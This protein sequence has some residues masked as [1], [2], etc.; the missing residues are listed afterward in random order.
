MTKEEE[1]PRMNALSY[2]Y[3]SGDDVQ[4]H[5]LLE[6]EIEMERKFLKRRDAVCNILECAVSM[7]KRVFIISD[8][9]MTHDMLAKLLEDFGITGYENLYVSSEYRTAKSEGLFEVVKTELN[10]E[11]LKWVH[12]GDNVYTDIYPAQKLGIETFRIYGTV[13]LLESSMYSGILENVHSLEENIVSASFAAEA[14]QDPFRI[15]GKNG[16][17]TIDTPDELGRLLIAPV[18]L[19]YITWLIGT[20]KQ[21]G[22][23][24]MVFPSRDG[25]LLKRIYDEIKAQRRD[26]QL[27]DSIYLYTSR[28]AARIAAASCKEDVYSIIEFD[29]PDNWKER[30]Q[31]RF[32]IEVDVQEDRKEVSKDLMEQLL[33]SCAKERERYQT[34]LKDTGIWNRNCGLVDFV[35]LGTVQEALEK[36]IGRSMRGYYFVRRSP[37][38]E[39]RKKMT[40][41]SL[42]PMSGDFQME[43][44]IYRFYY[45]LETV[46]TSYE[47]TFKMMNSD[48][49]FRFYEEKRSSQELDQLRRIHHAIFEYCMDMIE[50]LPNLN[51]MRAKV[52][53]YDAILGFFSLD[54][55]KI[56]ETIVGRHI[57]YDEFMEKKVTD[58]N[59]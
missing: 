56:E 22:I 10:D 17:L 4:I 39:Q 41:S 36:L 18:V 16:K 52:D 25:Y 33:I 48:G 37:D 15:Y 21:D 19:K 24:C 58:M 2:L 46:I 26:L 32:E 57:N 35:A 20:I 28:R 9:Y 23:D 53:I 30:I 55:T 34:Y 29:S 42:Y 3:A 54:Y 50:L 27:P 12:I 47:P 44:Q 45:F 8:M 6:L 5:C 38:T 11:S 7:G 59:R 13:E 31:K 49:T 40:C 43:F 1:L 51:M 14:F